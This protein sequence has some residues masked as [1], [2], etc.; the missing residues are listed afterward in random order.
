MALSATQSV[1]TTTA[2]APVKTISP[3]S[4]AAQNSASGLASA[5]SSETTPLRATAMTG[6]LTRVRF[7]R[8]GWLKASTGDVVHPAPAVRYKET[9]L[10]NSAGATARAR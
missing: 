5:Q 1:R 8:A 9:L 6:T 10:A 2:A 4:I 3:P 7:A